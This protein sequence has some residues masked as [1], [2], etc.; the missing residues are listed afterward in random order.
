MEAEPAKQPAE[1]H[2]RQPEKQGEKPASS[3]T[4]AFEDPEDGVGKEEAA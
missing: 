2:E 4:R 1:L 3:D